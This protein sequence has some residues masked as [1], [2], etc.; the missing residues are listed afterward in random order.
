MTPVETQ[1]LRRENSY[2]KQRCAQLEGDIVDLESQLA[3]LQQSQER[4]GGRRAGMEPRPA[5]N[6]PSGPLAGGQE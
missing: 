3:R 6:P 5:A 4:L 1:A 2:L